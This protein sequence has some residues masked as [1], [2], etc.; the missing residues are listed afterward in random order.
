MA[1]A[2]PALTKNFL[3]IP[4]PDLF[5]LKIFIGSNKSLFV[6]LMDLVCLDDSGP[7][8]PRSSQLCPKRGQ[9]H[10]PF[11]GLEF[12]YP[13]EAWTREAWARTAT[14]QGSP[15]VYRV[16]SHG[17]NKPVPPRTALALMSKQG[18]A[19]SQ[20]ESMQEKGPGLHCRGPLTSDS[21]GQEIICLF[22]AP[23]GPCGNQTSGLARFKDKLNASI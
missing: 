4:S 15:E 19:Q 14:W 11:P 22:S 9:H 8:C 2:C 20:S 23:R 6:M 16:R 21:Q 1:S 18:V 7:K 10:Q 13:W 17:G 12:P 5:L 3:L